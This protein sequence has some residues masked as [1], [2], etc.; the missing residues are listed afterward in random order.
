MTMSAAVTISSPRGW[1]S[2]LIYC[3]SQ[4]R[5]EPR[6]AGPGLVGPACAAQHSLLRLERQA[7]LGS[8]AMLLPPL[9]RGTLIRALQA[10]PGRRAPRRRAP[11]HGHLPQHRLD[12]GADAR[13][14][15]RVAVRERQPDAQIPLHLG[16]G[17][18]RPG[19]GP[20]ARRHQYRPS[21]QAGGRGAGRPAHQGARRLS[22]AAARGQIREQQPHRPPARMREEGACAMSRS[23]TCTFR[24]GTGSPSSPIR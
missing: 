14:A 17:G 16:A 4:L 1:A 23:R 6:A 18:G 11:R 2:L 8:R 19:P 10:L 5:R 24:A 21:Q 15:R 13:R 3:P 9:L 22:D 7:A 20:G 12:A